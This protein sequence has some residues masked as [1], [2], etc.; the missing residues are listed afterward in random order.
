MTTSRSTWRTLTLAVILLLMAVSVAW[1]Q[2]ESVELEGLSAAVPA[3]WASASDSNSG[4]IYVANEQAALDTLAGGGGAMTGEQIGISIATPSSLGS[5]GIDSNAAPT[6]AL[7]T[8]LSLLGSDAVVAKENGFSVAA[9]SAL[10]SSEMIPGGEVLLYAFAFA[11]GTVMV[12]IQKGDEVAEYLTEDVQ[13]VL[14]SIAYTPVAEAP[15][16]NEEPPVAT[17]E[18]VPAEGTAYVFG[19]LNI[20]IADGWVTREANEFQLDIANSEAASQAMQNDTTL[21]KGAFTISLVV[22]AG[23]DDLGLTV[24]TPEA[25]AGQIIEMAELTTEGEIAPLDGVTVP[26]AAV[27]VS[28]EDVELGQLIIVEFPQGL[29]LLAIEYADNPDAHGEAV[30]ALINGITFEESATEPVVLTAET[31]GQWAASASGSSQYGSS[32]WSFEQAT[33]EPDTDSCGD[34][35]TAWASATS[36]GKDSLML[37]YD[38]A[39]IPTQVNI[40]QTYNP[41]AIILIELSSSASGASFDLPDSADDIGNTPCPGVFMVDVSGITEPVD[42]VTI[43]L[44]QTRTGSWNEIDAVELVGVPAE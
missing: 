12:A 9:A 3:G 8:F 5:M 15:V 10:A 40:Y 6:V 41:G 37:T 35:G 33:G 21:P 19:G 1:A 26:T 31:I 20:P 14:S 34:I 29:V 11:D 2:G 7:E 30:L 4:S 36:T 43:Y 23:V 27:M 38:E 18:P 25:M 39:V 16:A 42:T 32:S 17:E 24:D 22:P 28:G 13:A 44:D